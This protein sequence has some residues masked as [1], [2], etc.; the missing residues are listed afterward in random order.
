M[1]FFVFAGRRRLSIRFS[2]LSGAGF[3]I[4]ETRRCQDSANYSAATVPRGILA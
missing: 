1:N 2:H 4:S 3:A